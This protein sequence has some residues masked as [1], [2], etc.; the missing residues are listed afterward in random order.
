MEIAHYNRLVGNS[1]QRLLGVSSCDAAVTPEVAAQ[2][3][4]AEQNK[5]YFR[6]YPKGDL[7]GQVLK[8]MILPWTWR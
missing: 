1:L 4:E 6:A 5:L 8:A 3:L 2:V 7:K